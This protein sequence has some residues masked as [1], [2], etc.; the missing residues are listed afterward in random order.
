MGLMFGPCKY[1]TESDGSECLERSAESSYIFRGVND[2]DW[3]IRASTQWS[4]AKWSR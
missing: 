1:Q 4:S 3:R 2:S